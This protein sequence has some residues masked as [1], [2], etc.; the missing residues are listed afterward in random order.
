M[1]K[2]LLHISKLDEFK[3]WLDMKKIP[4]RPARGGVGTYQVLQVCKDGKHWNCVYRRDSMPEH[5]STDKH[6]DSLV[7]QFAKFRKTKI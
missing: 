7:H 1:S 6:L 5:F 2:C 3:A 4:H